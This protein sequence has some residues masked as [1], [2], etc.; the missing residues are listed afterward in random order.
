M[1][2]TLP[3]PLYLGDPIGATLSG[4]PYLGVPIWAIQIAVP[5]PL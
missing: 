1:G 4:R 3:K 5:S 2:R